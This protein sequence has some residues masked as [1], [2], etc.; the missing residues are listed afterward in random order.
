MDSLDSFQALMGQV[1]EGDET[2]AAEVFHHFADRLRELARRRLFARLQAKLDADDVLQSVFRSFF[3]RHRQ[4]EF[5]LAGMDHLWAIL[6]LITL[7]KCSRHLEHYQAARRDLRREVAIERL[8]EDPALCIEDPTASQVVVLTE[9]LERLFRGLAP[10]EREVLCLH[11][12]GH[13]HFEISG[14][15]G[16]SVRTVRRSL[17]HIRRY[18][19]ALN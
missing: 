12:Q 10:D 1:R 16:R 17:D 9:L 18:V 19:E 15:V 14:Q 5:D 4:G 2:A 11:L 3:V 13:T 8:P 7:R 6:T